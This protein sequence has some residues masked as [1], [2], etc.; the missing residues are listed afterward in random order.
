MGGPTLRL[1]VDP[2]FL[3]EAPECGALLVEEVEVPSRSRRDGPAFLREPGNE[4]ERS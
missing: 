1:K 2:G 4:E 3:P